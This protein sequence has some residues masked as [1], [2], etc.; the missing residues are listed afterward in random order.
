MMCGGHSGRK[1]IDEEKREYFLGVRDQVEAALGHA[2]GHFEPVAYTSQV[3]A[4]TI[5]WLVVRIAEGTDG[6]AHVK[7]FQPLPYT[8]QGP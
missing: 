5:Y 2:V 4:G 6:H 7:I 3:V 8:G 1:E